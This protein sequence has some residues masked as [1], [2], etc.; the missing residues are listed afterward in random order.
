[1]NSTIINILFLELRLSREGDVLKNSL[2]LNKKSKRN[3]SVIILLI[4]IIIMCFVLI[5]VRTRVPF[6]VQKLIENE[7]V[8]DLKLTIYYRDQHLLVPY[9]WSVQD[10]IEDES[11]VNK[12]TVVGEELEKYI[13]SFNKINNSTLKYAFRKA[14]Y[15]DADTYYVLESKKN[16]KLFDVVMCGISDDYVTVFFNGIEVKYDDVFYTVIEPFKATQ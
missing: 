16:G 14:K 6:N 8:S 13:D 12:I 9:N 10:L 4:T 3:K 2:Y 15:L 7:N 5:C 1:M 11:S